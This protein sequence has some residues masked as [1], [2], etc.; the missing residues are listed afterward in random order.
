MSQGFIEE[1]EVMLNNFDSHEFGS[2]KFKLVKELK[3]WGEESSVA[4]G[5]LDRIWELWEQPAKP[6]E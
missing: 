1:E 3:K 5:A 2:F 6:S 4:S